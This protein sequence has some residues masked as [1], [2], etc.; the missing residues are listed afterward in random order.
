[1]NTDKLRSYRFSTDAQWST[2]LFIQADPEARRASGGIRPFPTYARPGTR[3]QSNGAHAPV[4]TRAG[5]IFWCDEKCTIHRLSTCDDSPVAFSAPSAIARAGRIVAT[6]GGLWV[7]GDGPDSLE[8][9]D[10]HTLS[11]LSVVNVPDLRIIDLSDAGRGC[12]WTLLEREGIWQS[13]CVD[14]FGRQLTTVAFEG[15]SAVVAFAF[16]RRSQRFAVLTGDPHPRLYWFSKEGGSALFSLPVAGLRPCFEAHVLGSDYRDRVFLAGADGAEFGGR[17]YVVILDADGN[18]L[19]DLPLDSQ[20]HPLRGV[21]ASRSSLLVAGQRGL[22]R[23]ETAEVASADVEQ[24]QC[25]VMTPAL[26][27]PDREDRRRWLRVEATAELPEGT[28]LEIFH[29][30]TD[31]VDEHE[32]LSTMAADNSLP[33]SQRVEGLL[34]ELAPGFRRTVF[35]GAAGTEGMQE[36]SAKLFDVRE[37]YLW[38]FVTLTA[39]S[40][41]RLPRLSELA[42]YYPGRTLMEDLPAIYQREEE[43][44]GSFLRALVGVI[45]ATTQGLDARIASMGS[46]VHPDTAQ[47]PW[48]NFI[49]RWLG[50]PWNDSLSIEQKKAVIKRAAD[51]SKGRGT[52]AGLEALLESLFPGSPR[53]FRVTD[54]TADFGFAVVGG[55][56]CSGSTLPALLAGS[57]RWDAELNSRA[58]LGY[59]RLPSAGQ[60]EDGDWQ[61]AGKIRVGVAATAAERTSTEPCLLDLIKQMVPLMARVELHWVAPHALR[62][63]RLDGTMTLEPEPSPH[64]GTDAITGLA[65]LPERAGP[66]SAGGAQIG[67]RLQ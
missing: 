42:V 12:V 36:Y 4:V 33:A 19:G 28:S 40:G 2:C 31:R 29:A 9:F 59:T 18:R 56:S 20:D 7:T 45:E 27:S 10:E 62:S 65:R 3:Y 49:A 52:R 38:V 24:A 17:P 64:L 16:L 46:Q 15:I 13:I 32:R 5:D 60:P 30:S 66:L 41:A 22:L 6:S 55:K 44:P 43:R 14:R 57:T 26:F 50:V 8:R 39:T 11:R 53:R 47:E 61:L 54:A 58:V 25:T 34:A 37:R 48:L 1:M 21:T 67:H 63:N 35:R 51:L 23:F